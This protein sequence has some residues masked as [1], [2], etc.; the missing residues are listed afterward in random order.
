[1]Q[2]QKD[3]KRSGRFLRETFE[4]VRE[5]KKGRRPQ[6]D[7]DA[8]SFTVCLG[9]DRLTPCEKPDGNGADNGGETEDEA[10]FAEKLV[11]SGFHI[12]NTNSSRRDQIAQ[13]IFSELARDL[14]VLGVR[15]G[16]MPQ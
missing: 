4:A 9:V 5:D 12:L 11:L 15:K 10:E 2:D 8:K 14:V 13:W 16:L 6:S 1:L 7:K 3:P